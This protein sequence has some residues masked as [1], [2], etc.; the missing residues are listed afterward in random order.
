MLGRERY[1]GG[2]FT[3]TGMA[4]MARNAFHKTGSSS[5]KGSSMSGKDWAIGG[6]I[7]GGILG[8]G[9]AGVKLS[10][11]RD[12]RKTKKMMEA[13]HKKIN[14]NP[15]LETKLSPEELQT[16]NKINEWKEKKKQFDLSN[17][18]IT[19]EEVYK[20]QDKI[21]KTTSD[22]SEVVGTEAE[23]VAEGLTKL[24][25]VATSHE[26]C[27]ATCAIDSSKLACTGCWDIVE[28]IEM[29]AHELPCPSTCPPTSFLCHS[30]CP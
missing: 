4:F 22:S 3:S 30:L 19:R 29:F 15:D 7:A 23:S 14:E 1:A 9:Y 6:G 10:V 11:Y 16:F 25:D 20:L 2:A 8:T 5:S 28:S 26:M 17:D 13:I 12:N 21:N 24:G 27:P 18:D